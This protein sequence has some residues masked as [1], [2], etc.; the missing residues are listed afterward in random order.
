VLKEK[1]AVEI[2]RNLRST[3]LTRY[4]SNVG[5]RPS[6]LSRPVQWARDAVEAWGDFQVGHRIS[7]KVGKQN[8]NC[9]NMSRSLCL[10]LTRLS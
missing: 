8:N 10:F 9:S 5:Q 1:R 7:S 4:L 3:S 6:Q 2:V